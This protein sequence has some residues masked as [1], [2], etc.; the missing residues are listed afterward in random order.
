MIIVYGYNTIFK[1]EG[2][3]GQA[4]CHNCGYT[5]EHTLCRQ[6]NQ[7]TLFWIPIISITKQR[8]KMCESCGNIIPMNKHDY[9]EEKKRIKKHH[10]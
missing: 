7:T 9:N 3:Q 1:R 5:I 8:G 4:V 6:I 2:S 10:I